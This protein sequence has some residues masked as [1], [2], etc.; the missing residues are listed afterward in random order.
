LLKSRLDEWLEAWLKP[1]EG[2]VAVETLSRDESVGPAVRAL[3]IKVVE[4]GGVIPRQWSGVDALSKEQRYKLHLAKVY[5]G[6]LEIYVYSA[7]RHAAQSR[8]SELCAARGWTL[9]ELPD[10]MPAVIAVAG[11]GVPSTYRRAGNQAIRIDL[12]ERLFREG[13]RQRLA[14]SRRTFV[15]DESLG[16]SMGLTLANQEAL[17]RSCGFH[18]HTRRQLADGEYG[19][20]FPKL[21]K[22]LPSKRTGAIPGGKGQA[23]KQ[24]D[25]SIIKHA[26]A[27]AAGS[28]FSGLAELMRG[29]GKAEA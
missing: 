28:A 4:G 18:T 13:H 20:P 16:L 1:L 9:P 24:G 22:W 29:A 10:L 11:Q 23:G 3:L 17:M 27:S 8:W 21:W 14:S 12:A 25:E 19:P 7:L 26:D 2:L 6:S 5:I 15:F